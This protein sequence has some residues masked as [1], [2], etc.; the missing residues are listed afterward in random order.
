MGTAILPKPVRRRRATGKTEGREEKLTAARNQDV[1]RAGI[2]F[3]A[4]LCLVFWGITAKFA[5]WQKSAQIDSTDGLRIDLVFDEYLSQGEEETLLVT[6]INQGT[7]PL[8]E[9]TTRFIYTGETPMAVGVDTANTLTFG[10]L[11]PG[12]MKTKKLT[13]GPVWIPATQ[14]NELQFMV[15]RRVGTGLEPKS[16]KYSLVM[17]F[18]P[19]LHRLFNIAGAALAALVVAFFKILLDASFGKTA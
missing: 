17:A 8:P 5:L 6:A 13:L 9:V 4:L 11:E 15:W 1:V 7:Q 19:L 3:I 14:T 12:E 2:V 16:D 18:L 10:A